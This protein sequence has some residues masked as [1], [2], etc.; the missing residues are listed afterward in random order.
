VEGIT[1]YKFA[2]GLELLVF[3]DASKPNTKVNITYLV[4]SRYEGPG[5]AG[6]AHLLEHMLFKGSPIRTNIPQELTEQSLYRAFQ[7]HQ[8]CPDHDGNMQGL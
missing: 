5:E 2:N 1:E 3:P 4:G 8:K 7:Q 6:M